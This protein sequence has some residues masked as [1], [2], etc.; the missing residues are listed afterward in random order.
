[1]PKYHLPD[2]LGTVGWKIRKAHGYWE[3]VL[4]WSL[5]A[6]VHV[7]VLHDR[8]DFEKCFLKRW[9]QR[10]KCPKG[11]FYLGRCQHLNVLTHYARSF[12]LI[13]Q[14]CTEVL[15]W[16][17]LMNMR[18]LRVRCIPWIWGIGDQMHERQH[19]KTSIE[20]AWVRSECKAV[21]RGC[22]GRGIP[23]C[24]GDTST[25]F[26]SYSIPRCNTDDSRGVHHALTESIQNALW[27]GDPPLAAQCSLLAWSPWRHSTVSGHGAASEHPPPNDACH[28]LQACDRFHPYS[29]Q[30]EPL[31][32]TAVNLLI[33]SSGCLGNLA[34]FSWSQSL[35][36][37]VWSSSFFCEGVPS[38]PWR[39]LMSQMYRWTCNEMFLWGCLGWYPVFID[40]ESGTPRK[41]ALFRF[42]LDF[43]P[44]DIQSDLRSKY[45]LQ[46]TC[47]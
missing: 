23:P 22:D 14:V 31:L 11:D 3:I 21:C 32:Q 35:R 24:P 37:N 13:C 4:P 7:S 47:V 10:D 45:R 44:N 46:A 12:F 28:S 42:K 18:T 30:F 40:S 34:S 16:A 36:L 9:S 1:M 38:G 19:P 20:A 29:K 25:G 26:T 43:Y 6:K 5:S 17:W 15:W 39:G 33:L 41:L 2:L 8:C 27:G